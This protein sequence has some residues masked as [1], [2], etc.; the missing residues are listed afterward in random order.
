MYKTLAVA[1]IAL[2]AT[3]GS[4]GSRWDPNAE[5]VAGDTMG[6]REASAASVSSMKGRRT[7]TAVGEGVPRRA[8]LFEAGVRG[9]VSAVHRQGPD[10]RDCDGDDEDPP[11][12]VIRQPTEPC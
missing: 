12:R 3:A 11:D 10:H 8:R 6:A 9:D 4:G 2:I 1:T 7:G 5:T